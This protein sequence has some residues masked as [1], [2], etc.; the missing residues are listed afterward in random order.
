MTQEKSPSVV[1]GAADTKFLQI[2]YSIFSMLNQQPEQLVSDVDPQ[3]S[4]FKNGII[5]VIPDENI[6]ISELHKRIISDK[7][8]QTIEKLRHLTTVLGKD[9]E[10]TQEYKRTLPYF[11]ASGTYTRR[12]N[13]SLVKPAD[14]VQI[15]LD[16][17]PEHVLE[18]AQIFCE[19]CNH[20]VLSFVSPSGNGLKALVRAKFTNKLEY[21]SAFAEAARLFNDAGF[22]VDAGAKPLSQPL[23]VS[24]DKNAYLDLRAIYLS[25]KV[26][27]PEEPLTRQGITP[28]ADLE[29][30]D[31]RLKRLLE[32]AI[33]SELENIRTAA[34]GSG[35]RTFNRSVIA[36]AGYAHT[37]AIEARDIKESFITAFL[38]RG[39]HTKFEAN[40]K[41]DDA[42]N[43]GRKQHKAVRERGV[44]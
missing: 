42:W 41:F 8:R 23:Y 19:T 29:I 1:T 2:D 20:V 3:V 36:I 17:L 12:A 4:Y 10:R 18:S 34:K 6:S 37:G 33:N 24:Y 27:K 22:K 13:N 14:L 26:C 5:D 39:G 35:S 16:N 30:S 40:R 25:Y 31:Y 32:T 44:A 7:Y 9:N 28:V 11:I 38:E 43:Y 15:D 21:D